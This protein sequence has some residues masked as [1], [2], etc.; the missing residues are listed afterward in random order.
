VHQI[1]KMDLQTMF[2]RTPISLIFSNHLPVK[3]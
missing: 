2:N 1:S 3:V